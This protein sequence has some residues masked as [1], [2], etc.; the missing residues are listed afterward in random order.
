MNIVQRILGGVSVGGL[1]NKGST[2]VS[3]SVVTGI[4]ALAGGGQTGATLLTGQI[5]SVDTVATAADSVALPAPS[6][7]GQEIR[8]LNNS[9]NSMQVFG[10]GTD[11]IN[12]VAT[13]TGVAQAGGKFAIYQALSV[14]TA[15]NWYRNLSA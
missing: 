5:N 3:G 2:F 7:V 8:V 15:A 11:K 14:G 13:G 10:S 1:L 9:A 12:G 6:Y 4:T